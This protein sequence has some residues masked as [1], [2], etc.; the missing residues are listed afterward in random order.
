MCWLERE[1]EANNTAEKTDKE[2]DK[3]REKPEDKTKTAGDESGS[4][5]EIVKEWRTRSR[6]L[7]K[8]VVIIRL[9]VVTASCDLMQ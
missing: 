1:E 4:D 6:G 9:S 8:G 5:K 2:I 7:E 3:E